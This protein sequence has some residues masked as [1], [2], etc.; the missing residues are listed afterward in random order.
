[1]LSPNVNRLSAAI[2]LIVGVTSHE[3]A[4]ID[5]NTPTTID[6]QIITDDKIYVHDAALAGGGTAVS[7]TNTTINNSLA[8]QDGDGID[9]YSAAPSDFNTQHS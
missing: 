1:M 6:G 3:V 2:A 7:I 8:G 4:A 9:I 5:I